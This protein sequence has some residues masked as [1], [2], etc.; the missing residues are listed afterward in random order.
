MNNTASIKAQIATVEADM[1]QA[2]TLAD[3]LAAM[4]TAAQRV[5]DCR[6]DLEHLAGRLAEAETADR[7]HAG[8][9]A[10]YDVL[11]VKPGMDSPTPASR[12]TVT[13]IEHGHGLHGPQEAMRTLRLD[14]IPEDLRQALAAVPKHIPAY[15]LALADDPYQALREHAMHAGRGY[16]SAPKAWEERMGRNAQTF[17]APGI[18]QL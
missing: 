10:K 9:L 16:W 18:E 7:M 11:A 12:H 14:G 15:I 6:R 2:Q 5:A 13:F 4:Q 17:I 1:A 8:A 3:Q